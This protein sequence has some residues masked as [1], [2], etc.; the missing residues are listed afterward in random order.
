MQDGRKVVLFVNVPPSEDRV[1]GYFGVSAEELPAA[2][3]VTMGEA[4]MKK[5]KWDVSKQITA[6]NIAAYLTDFTAGKLKPFLKSDPAPDAAENAKAA[7]KVVTGNTFQ[8][9]VVDNDND[10]LLEVYAPWCG[11]CKSLAPTYEALGE[12]AIAKG[13]K[14]LVIAKMDGTTNEI[15]FP[16][17]QVRGFPTILFFPAGKKTAAV[18]F[19]GSRDVA[20]FVSFL[21]QHATNPVN[22]EDDDVDAADNDEL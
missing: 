6:E 3:L 21:K 2:V 1:L 15:D 13:N 12:A 17:V 7:V 14:K 19:D 5:Y 11:H 22:L 10:V 20:G 18:D 9:L 8:E 16:G 4:G